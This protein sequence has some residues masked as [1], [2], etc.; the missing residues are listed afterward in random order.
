VP[1][2]RGLHKDGEV[3]I[4]REMSELSTRDPHQGGKEEQEVGS[5]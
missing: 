3:G 1:T 2:W 5:S 4:F